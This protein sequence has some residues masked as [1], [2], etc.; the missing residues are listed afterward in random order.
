MI[1]LKF[2][3]TNP[4]TDRF[5]SLGAWSGKIPI[6]NKFW[7]LQTLKTDDIVSVNFQITVNRDHAGLELWLGLFG[8]S[9]NFLIYDNRH[10]NYDEQRWETYD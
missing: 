8:Y 7:E 1:N 10:W 2:D 6:P 4:F 9:V 3:L 5:E